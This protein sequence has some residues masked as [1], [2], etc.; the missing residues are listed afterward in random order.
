VGVPATIVIASR[1]SGKVAELRSLL[2]VWGVGELRSIAEFPR[3]REVAEEG[4]SYAENARVKA[5]SA[6]AASG[7]AA[8]G[9]DSGLEVDA[10]GGRPGIHSARY[11]SPGLSDADRI[12]RLLAELDGVSETE[13][14]A[15]FRAVA[16]LAWPDGC[17]VEATGECRGRIALAPRG[18]CGFGYDPVFVCAKLG[19]TFAEISPEEKAR[20]SHR[21]RALRALR[22]AVVM[23]CGTGGEG[24][25]ES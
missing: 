5:A 10:L 15:T 19:R 7:L 17:V 6:A 1:N 25:G 20:L 23:A 11:G 12:D 13:R 18:T 16:V 14:G 4:V 22:E 3:V 9:E 21:G 24:D 2:A 8:L